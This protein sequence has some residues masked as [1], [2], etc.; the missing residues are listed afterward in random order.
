MSL[1]TEVLAAVQAAFAPGDVP[2][3]Q[4]ALER[5]GNEPHEAEV[6]RVQ[7]AIVALS[8]GRLDDLLRWVHDVKIDYR[9]VLAARQL[10]PVSSAD[11][12][13]LQESARALIERWGK[14]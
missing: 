5:Y 10:G 4:A 3:A 7:L 9:D 2:A 8:G 13:R 12:Q 6:K 14:R 1:D 11:G